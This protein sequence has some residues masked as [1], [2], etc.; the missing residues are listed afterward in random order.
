MPE[1]TPGPW[2]VERTSVPDGDFQARIMAG[3]TIIVG[4]PAKQNGRANIHWPQNAALIAAAPELLE[5]LKFLLEDTEPEVVEGGPR[6]YIELS[7]LIAKA[8]SRARQ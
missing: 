3:K 8:E 1:H 6:K 2:A 5:A 4:E 7:K